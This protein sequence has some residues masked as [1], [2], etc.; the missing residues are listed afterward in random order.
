MNE[1][2]RIAQVREFAERMVQHNT[3]ANID[4][5]ERVRQVALDI[6]QREGANLQVLELAALLHDIGVA[7]DKAT[8]YEI[9]AELSRGF[10]LGLNYDD[11]IVQQVCHAIVTHSRYG[12]PEPKTLEAK[13]IH[14]A[15]AVEY[16]GAIG[17]ARAFVRGFENGS[18]TGDVNS[19]PDVINQ[20]ISHIGVLYTQRARDIIDDRIQFMRLFQARLNQELAGEA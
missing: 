18:Y 3:F 10:L 9:S 17:L 12:G 4:H 7:A 6:G 13:I 15:D 5:A 19:V 14:D 1:A 20:L 11:D 8:H 2:K 16:V